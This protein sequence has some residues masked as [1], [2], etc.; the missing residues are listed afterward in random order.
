MKIAQFADGRTI[1]RHS[2]GEYLT[3]I[4]GKTYSCHSLDE[5]INFDIAIH[6]ELA[7][8]KLEALFDEFNKHYYNGE[9]VKPTVTC[10]PDLS[11]KAYG[12]ITTQEV[13]VCNP[14]KNNTGKLE[15]NISANYINRPFVD[16]CVTLLHEMAHIYNMQNGIADT[17]NN[18]YYHNKRFKATAEAHGLVIKCLPVIGWSNSFLALS[19][20]DY[21]ESLKTGFDFARATFDTINIDGSWGQ[22]ARP[23]REGGDD[24]EE[25]TPKKKTQKSFT[26][27]CPICGEKI[28]SNNPDLNIVCGL[29]SGKFYRLK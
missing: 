20:L 1:E 14:E 22:T 3:T 18:G 25:E 7:S 19:E 10:Y 29:D 23:V 27:V 17:S 21:I 12:W 16:I 5:A 9:L 24:D 15:L 11:R 6:P 13:W 4:Y 8:G 28:K 26:Y 2:T